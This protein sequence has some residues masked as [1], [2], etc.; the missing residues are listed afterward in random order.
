VVEAG[1]PDQLAGEQLLYYRAIAVEYDQAVKRD[2][3]EPERPELEAALASFAPAGAVLELAAGTGQWTT[4]LTRYATR[5]TVVDAAPEMLAINR[6][7]WR[8]P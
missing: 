6:P 3:G 4:V 7:T 8:A 2:R 5:L 1:D